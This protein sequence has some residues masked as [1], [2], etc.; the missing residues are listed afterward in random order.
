MSVKMAKLS[1][2]TVILTM[3]SI[4]CTAT[5]VNAECELIT[6]K[7]E[8]SCSAFKMIKNPS[9]KLIYKENL[10]KFEDFNHYF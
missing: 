7:M 3:A 6:T 1:L 8:I 4:L 2:P 10:K 9:S 5:S